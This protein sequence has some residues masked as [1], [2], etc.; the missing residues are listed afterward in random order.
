MAALVRGGGKLKCDHAFDFS[1]VLRAVST[2]G[3]RWLRSHDN[4]AIAPVTSVP[5]AA[6]FVIGQRLIG[7]KC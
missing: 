1:P 2:D 6:I 3:A 4:T 7:L 5:M